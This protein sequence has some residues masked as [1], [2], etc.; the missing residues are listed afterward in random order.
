MCEIFSKLRLEISRGVFTV[1]FEQLFT[2]PLL[3]KCPNRRFSWSVFSCIQAAANQIRLNPV[4]K[5]K[6]PCY[7]DAY[8]K[9]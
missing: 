8:L 4:D 1:S 5:Q 3:E 9:Y 7:F 6:K 2:L